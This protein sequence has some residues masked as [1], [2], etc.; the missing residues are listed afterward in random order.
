MPAGR[1]VDD[2][3]CDTGR[4]RRLRKDAKA[5]PKEE[6]VGEG[7]LCVEKAE[8]RRCGRISFM[9]GASQGWSSFLSPRL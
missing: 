9:L 7:I 8:S 2:P 5:V 3:R 4:N 1:P 6:E